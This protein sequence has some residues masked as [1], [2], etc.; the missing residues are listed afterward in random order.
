MG[1]LWLWLS[2]TRPPLWYV[3]GSECLKRS[4]DAKA[5][6][7]WN[8]SSRRLTVWLLSRIFW[9][10]CLLWLANSANSKMFRE[11]SHLCQYFHGLPRIPAKI[12]HFARLKMPHSLLWFIIVSAAAS[13]FQPVSLNVSVPETEFLY[14]LLPCSRGRCSLQS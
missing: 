13:G 9:Q 2:L 7:S 5:T 10:R 1:L 4:D 12:Y 8:S 6:Q 3:L 11:N 14:D